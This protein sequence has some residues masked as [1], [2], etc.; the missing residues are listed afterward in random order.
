MIPLLKYGMIEDIKTVR[1]IRIGR[2][3]GVTIWITSLKWLGPIFF[4]SLYFIF[5][6]PNITL[7]LMERAY[8]SLVF[9]IAVE[10]TTTIHAFGH[11]LSGKMVDSAMDELLI[12][13]TRD[14]NRYYGDQSLVPG[15]IH[16]AR[17]LGGPLLN[18]IVAG[19]FIL[20]A[21]PAGTGFSSS[22]LNH[23]IA[24]NLFYG[25]GSFLPIR[26]VDGEVIW[27]EIFRL[28]RTR[29]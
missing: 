21:S 3:W 29:A 10:I 27:R 22:L 2:L 24:I 26:T 28:V 7:T 1:R 4:F 8:H 16:L 5:T 15:R 18:L 6:L 23:L 17:A 25:I 13:S 14:V 9:A 11:I 20:I 19:V 12:T